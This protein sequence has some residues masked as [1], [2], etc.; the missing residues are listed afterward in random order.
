M[1]PFPPLALLTADIDHEH[2]VVTEGE[3]GLRD[4][5]R[6]CTSVDDVL[7]V[8]HVRW[9]EQAFEVGKVVQK[10]G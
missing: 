10:T 9:L 4:P 6:P 2:I 3:D 8:W 1:D 7:F 5:D